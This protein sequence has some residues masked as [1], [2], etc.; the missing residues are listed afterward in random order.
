MSPA[1]APKWWR[2]PATSLAWAY[3]R[4][5]WTQG[6]KAGASSASQQRPHS[7]KAPRAVAWAATSSASRVLPIPGS[8]ASSTTPPRP[9]AGIQVGGE[10]GQF[11]RTADER[12]L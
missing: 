6:R 7:T 1:P 12:C 8:P 9:A 2:S 4:T 11:A 10:Y 3:A 5:T